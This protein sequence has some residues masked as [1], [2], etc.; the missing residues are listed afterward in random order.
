MAGFEG[1]AAGDEVHR[2]VVRV[3]DG[4]RQFLHLCAAKHGLLAALGLVAATVREVKHH[5]AIR[6]AGVAQHESPVAGFGNAQVPAIGG[7]GKGL[8]IVRIQRVAIGLERRAGRVQ[9]MP[10]RRL[11]LDLRTAG[12]VPQKVVVVPDRMNAQARVA[13]ELG[14]LLLVELIAQPAEGMQRKVVGAHRLDRADVGTVRVVVGRVAE[15]HQVRGARGADLGPG[16]LLFEALGTEAGSKGDLH[17]GLSSLWVADA[18]SRPET[19]P[20]PS[21]GASCRAAGLPS[22]CVWQDLRNTPL[23]DCARA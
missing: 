18:R 20:P 19:P 9:Q 22:P 1:E 12:A 21:M 15:Q 23:T 10:V 17:Q 3:L 4:R 11:P 6:V 16:R 7:L 13:H 8:R 5:R 2:L 14:E